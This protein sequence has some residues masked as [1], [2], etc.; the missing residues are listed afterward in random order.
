MLSTLILAAAL[1]ASAEVPMVRDCLHSTQIR[2][3]SVLDNK[4]I[5][6]ELRDRSVWKNTLDFGCPSLGFHQ[7]FSYQSHG[8]RLCDLDT[9]Q[10]FENGRSGATCGLGKFERQEGSIRE[11]TKADREMKRF[12]R[13][14]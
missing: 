4:T 5:L 6:F 13:G 9:I 2:S 3:T 10:V 8:A 12:A 7:A 11:L 1:S 14:R